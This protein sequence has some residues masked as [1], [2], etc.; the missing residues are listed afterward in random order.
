MTGAGAP[1][2]PGIIH[3]LRQDERIR[4][5]V[6]DADE[7]ATGRWLDTVFIQLPKAG[8][9]Q[10]I[11]TLLELCRTQAIDCILPLVTKEL[12]LFAQHKKDFEAQGTKVLV[13]N[14][15][16]IA[17]ANDK[18]ATYRFLKEKGID[19]PPFFVAGKVEDFVHAA[20]ALGHPQRSFVFKPSVAN[21]SR[22]VRIV[23]ESLNETDL[24]FNHKPYQ[25][26]ITYSHALEILSA[27]PFPELLLSAYLPGEEY[28]I[29]C[30][31]D[32]GNTV[33]AVPRSRTKMINGIS[34]QGSFVQDEAIIDY[35]R[36]I[37]AAIGLDGNIGLQVKRGEDGRPYLLEINPRVQGTIVAALGAGVNLPLLAVKR[38]MGLPVEDKELDVRWGTRFSRYWTEVFY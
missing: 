8:D 18:S 35:C 3:C 6:G 32:R 14:P 27:R 7:Q 19:V 37:V 16:A 4:L 26:H 33:L 25:L 22:G 29:D 23:S 1:G 2:A 10:Y 12:L 20:F 36:S 11:Q 15:E 38:A 28:S 21:G 24:L 31:A 9:P 5:T 13:S 17:I 34:V 30:L